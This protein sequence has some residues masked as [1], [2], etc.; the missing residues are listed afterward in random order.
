MSHQ[1]LRVVRKMDNKTTRLK[2]K[3]MKKRHGKDYFD[4]LRKNNE[5]LKNLSEKQILDWIEKWN[6]ILDREIWEEPWEEDNR[7]TI[8]DDE[9]PF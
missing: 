5:E 8:P 4:W 9:L 3:Q 6:D 2:I 7:E 1:F